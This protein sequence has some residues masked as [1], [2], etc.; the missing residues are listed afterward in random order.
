MAA[1][2]PWTNVAADRIALGPD[3]ELT[4]VPFEVTVDETGRATFEAEIT[5]LDGDTNRSDDTRLADVEVVD[6]Q[7]RV[8]LMASG[9]TRE[10]RFLRNQLQRDD[11]FET[12]V[13]LQSSPSG[14]P[15]VPS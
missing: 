14:I 13:L 5:S 8:L 3:G 12:D 1:D 6:R 7:L 9:A 4:L 11:G 2:A 15:S 10:Y